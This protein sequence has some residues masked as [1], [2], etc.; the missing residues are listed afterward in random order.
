MQ[1]SGT[2]CDTLSV[3]LAQKQKHCTVNSKQDFVSKYDKTGF[4]SPSPIL[5][6]PSTEIWKLGANQ[7]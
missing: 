3:A 5:S 7:I 2:V 1:L 6:L 4:S